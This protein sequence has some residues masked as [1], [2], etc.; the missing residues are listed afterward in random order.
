MQRIST[1]SL[2]RGLSR[3]LNRVAAG[4]EIVITRN[5]AAVARLVPENPEAALRRRE[6]ALAES[7]ALRKALVASGK[8][9]TIEEIIRFKNEGYS[10]A[11]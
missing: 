6:Q 3:I 2:R 4:E 10:S 5:G 11:S 1:T 7:T 9:L 8:A